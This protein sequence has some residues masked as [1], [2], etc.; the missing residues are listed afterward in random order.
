GRTHGPAGWS[1]ALDPGQYR[2][3]PM[4]LAL[5]G[6]SRRRQGML[7]TAALLAVFLA[8]VGAITLQ[9]RGADAA[10]TS[11]F[12]GNASGWGGDSGNATGGDDGV[13]ASASGDGQTL[14]L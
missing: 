14:I 10:T 8:M 11:G 12:A 1:P 9:V 3:K 2:R 6:K 13:A 4:T 5:Y 7:I